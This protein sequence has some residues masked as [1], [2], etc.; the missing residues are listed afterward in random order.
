MDY[1]IVGAGL[2]G[3]V[4]ARILADH[5]L[6]VAIFER[7]AHLG[8]NVHDHVH[9]SG[10]PV[11]TYGP[12]FFRTSS[13][14]VWDFVRRFGSFRPYTL[15]L[16]TEADGRCEPWPL[17]P[18]ALRRMG[19]E[20]VPRPPAAPLESFEDA[21]LAK[22]PRIVYE[23]FVRGYTEK[24]WGVPARLLDPQLARRID[25]R[26]H[27][28]DR[29]KRSR[30]QGLPIEGYAA[31]MGKMVEGIPVR[32]GV[33]YLEAR[34]VV[35][36]RLLVVY[37]GPIDAW[38]GHDL[39]RLAYRGQ[40]RE[41][42]YRPSVDLALPGA[43]VNNPGAGDHVRTIE[44]KQLMAREDALRIRGTLLTR[45]TPWS[46]TDPDGF[47]Y[48]FQDA[49]NRALYERYAARAAATRALLIC[50]RLG[51]YRYYDMD[52]AIGRAMTLATRILRDEG[53]TRVRLA[54]P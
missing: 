12:H 22:M 43:V 25:V 21:C 23:R 44:W 30:Y 10:I 14:R 19:V 33:D 34:G 1:L 46:P 26:S 40:R 54:G 53:I 29:L 31:L 51:E 49:E 5:G 24:Q 37:T 38:F 9:E 20:Y 3:S 39:G 16:L 11:H 42:E 35:R 32:N 13:E 2:T 36:P 6:D 45:E 15:R 52:Q 7:R 4:I 48:P 17:T 8:G 41:H 47:E 27:E 28:D 50:G 18:S